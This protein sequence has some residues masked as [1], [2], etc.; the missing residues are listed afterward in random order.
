MSVCPRQLSNSA[1]E[2][3]KLLSP[4]YWSEIVREAQRIQRDHLESTLVGR[5]R[6]VLWGLP[7]PPP[8][9]SA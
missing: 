4:T 9:F 3:H 2:A 6:L 7:R 8:P 1:L 5:M